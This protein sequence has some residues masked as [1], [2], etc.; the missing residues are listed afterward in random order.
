MH[1]ETLI[2]GL[3]LVLLFG[4]SAIAAAGTC[5]VVTT[6]NVLVYESPSMGSNV[7][8]VANQGDQFALVTTKKF[9]YGVQMPGGLTGY[10]RKAN[11]SS[12]NQCADVAGSPS[13]AST[14]SSTLNS[15]TKPWRKVGIGVYFPFRA[16]SF[17]ED[18]LS[19]SSFDTIGT[20]DD[21][22][23]ISAPIVLQPLFAFGVK[24]NRSRR[25]SVEGLVDFTYVTY[26]DESA[27]ETV[28][29]IGLGGKFYYN[30][31]TQ[32]KFVLY[33]AGTG[34][35]QQT[36]VS[37]KPDEGEGDTLTL[38]QLNLLGHGGAEVFFFE[39]AP[40]LAFLFEVAVPVIALT[41]VSNTNDT[42][43]TGLF[44]SGAAIQLGVRYYFW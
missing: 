24:F 43:A 37:Y 30:F 32:E 38:A 27:E 23:S 13:G 2:L 25:F 11:A 28:Q 6:D 12:S 34:S 4:I 3:G 10:V 14:G 41:K 42:D 31:L 19:Y 26:G 8:G 39:S 44:L 21:G 20:Y 29:A 9:F 1:K 17:G 40:R 36:K 5:V 18:D 33:L 16:N 15:T 7:I 35:F 22:E